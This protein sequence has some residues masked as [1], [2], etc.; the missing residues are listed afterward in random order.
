[1]GV[2]ADCRH[3]SSR[4]LPTGDTVD[5]CA[6]YLAGSTRVVLPEGAHHLRQLRLC[7]ICGREMTGRAVLQPTGLE[8]A[9]DSHMCQACSTGATGIP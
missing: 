9:A 1:M 3:Y 2:R 4:S 7:A 6:V 8:R 5:G